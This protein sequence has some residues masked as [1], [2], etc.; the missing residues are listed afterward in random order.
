MRICTSQPFI[1]LY[2]K[3]SLNDIWRRQIIG[4]FGIVSLQLLLEHKANLSL[5]W[6]VRFLFFEVLR[7]L[8]DW[9]PDE[10]NVILYN[11]KKYSAGTGSFTNK[12]YEDFET[13]PKVE[14]PT[15]GA[16]KPISRF[17]HYQYFDNLVLSIFGNPII[18]S[19]ENKTKNPQHVFLTCRKF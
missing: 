12:P 6:S 9:S 3:V 8:K 15:R 7:P 4:G 16:H 13:S 14:R 19:N 5:F 17:R 18:V 11:V 10:K 2:I 1:E